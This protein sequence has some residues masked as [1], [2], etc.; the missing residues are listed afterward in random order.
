MQL[1]KTLSR[2]ILGFIIFFSFWFGLFIYSGSLTSGYHFIDDHQILTLTEQLKTSSVNSVIKDFYLVELHFRFRPMFNVVRVVFAFLFG[3]NFTFWAISFGLLGVLTSFFLFKFGTTIGFSF[4]Q[5]IIFALLTLVGVQSVMWYQY[6]DAENLGMFFLSI[7]LFLLAKSIFSSKYTSIYRAGF[8]LSMIFSSLSK[9]SFVIVIPAIL[10]LQQWL[11]SSK[12][13]VSL[14][15]A[16]KKNILSIIILTVVLLLEMFLIIYLIGTDPTGQTGI[17]NNILSMFFV[18]S[19]FYEIRHFN[20]FLIILFGV[21]LIIE[22]I[23]THKNSTENFLKDFLKITTFFFLLIFPQFALYFKSGIMDRYY[24]PLM[25]GFTFYLL[26]LTKKIWDNFHISHFTKYL[27]LFLIIFFLIEEVRVNTIPYLVKNAE[28]SRST[29][30]LLN[31]IIQNADEDSNIII[32]MDPAQYFELCKSL[33][34]YLKHFGDREKFSVKFTYRD[35]ITKIY[36]DSS[37][38]KKCQERTFKMFKNILFDSLKNIDDI[39][40]V[41]IFPQLE[42]N[43]L[44]ENNSWFDTGS[45]RRE[46]FKPYSVYYKNK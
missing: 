31:S 44:R 40:C 23:I 30:S 42:K 45:Y 17:D 38:Y 26:Y 35:H 19:F 8:L 10:F 22:N 13:N 12:N 33:I 1:K 34:D 24:L 46:E 2:D 4:I 3:S 6:G 27:Y 41:V 36:S 11:Y 20:I 21:F 9:E 5:S 28:D 14:F 18:R 15:T 7:S 32:V 37:F 43:F 25:I 39:Q 16:I 29:N